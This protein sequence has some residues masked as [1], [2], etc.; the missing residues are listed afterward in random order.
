MHTY[1]ICKACGIHAAANWNKHCKTDHGNHNPNKLELHEG[2]EPTKPWCGDWHEK[3]KEFVRQHLGPEKAEQVFVG[4]YEEPA[5]SV[6]PKS[7]IQKSMLY[8]R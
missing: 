6:M 7:V 2:Q 5:K 3:L 8:K 1:K 4:I